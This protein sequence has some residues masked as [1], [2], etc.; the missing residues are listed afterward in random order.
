MFGVIFLLTPPHLDI[1]R[2][3]SN[4]STDASLII[5]FTSFNRYF[6]KLNPEECCSNIRLSCL[7]KFTPMDPHKMSP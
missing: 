7:L 1:G 2:I 6:S 5:K 3:N 4:I